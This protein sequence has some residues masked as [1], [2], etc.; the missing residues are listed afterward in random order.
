[1]LTL[2]AVFLH[3]CELFESESESIYHEYCF[4]NVYP[5]TFVHLESCDEQDKEDQEA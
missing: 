1:M 5:V 2:D 3:G 4:R